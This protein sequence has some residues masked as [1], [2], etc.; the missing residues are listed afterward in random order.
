[1]AEAGSI[2][3]NLRLRIEAGIGNTL[4][5][6]GHA[7]MEIDLPVQVTPLNGAHSAGASIAIDTSALNSRLS[8]AAAAFENIAQG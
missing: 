6:I 2:K 5:D 8:A 4:T 3:V 7:D 1:M